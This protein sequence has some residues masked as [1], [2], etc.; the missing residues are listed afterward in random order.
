[1][2]EVFADYVLVSAGEAFAEAA[3]A[4]VEGRFG[5]SSGADSEEENTQ[6]PAV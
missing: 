6:A 1:M 2:A 4:Y 5:K 3:K